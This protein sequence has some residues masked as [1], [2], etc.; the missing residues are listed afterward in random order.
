MPAIPVKERWW[1]SR[2]ES[3]PRGDWG[4]CFS[5]SARPKA[6]WL[7]FKKFEDH[8]SFDST[9]I[10]PFQTDPSVVS[11]LGSCVVCNQWNESQATQPIDL[12]LLPTSKRNQS[13]NH[14]SVQRLWVSKAYTS[15]VTI[16]HRRM[17]E[18]LGPYLDDNF[19]IGKVYLIGQES[20]DELV[21][22]I[23]RKR[24]MLRVRYAQNKLDYNN[25]SFMPCHEC[26]RMLPYGSI[27]KRYVLLPELSDRS[28][29]IVEG[30]LLLPPEIIES[31]KLRDRIRWPNLVINP[32]L[33]CKELL[34]PIPSPFPATWEAFQSFII[35]RC[36]AMPF[37]RSCITGFSEPGDW[38]S[39]YIVRTG[40]P[41]CLNI[42][43]GHDTPYLHWTHLFFLRFRALF[44]KRV[45]ERIDNWCDDQLF[46]FLQDYYQASWRTGSYFPV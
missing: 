41:I 26:G 44:D 39:K 42:E 1:K 40:Q 5:H 21:T 38:V 13:F 16:M 9:G 27:G 8:V 23:D 19:V 20:I 29:R 33:A 24:V 43:R 34:D 6:S 4:I 45:A 10:V 46:E 31:L 17:L 36:G 15:H 32:V 7:Q 22:V 37:P 14:K 30:S 11:Q 12:P 18:S 35:E 25:R 2:A 3:D 28:P